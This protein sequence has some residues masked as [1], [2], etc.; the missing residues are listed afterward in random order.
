MESLNDIEVDE[1]G[2]A[3]HPKS[4]E[5]ICIAATMDAIVIATIAPKTLP[6]TTFMTP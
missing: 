2:R 4:D 5:V 3:Q 1:N 6:K